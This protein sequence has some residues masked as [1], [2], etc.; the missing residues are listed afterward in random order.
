[1]WGLTIDSEGSLYVSHYG[2]DRVTK[3]PGAAIVA[4][5]N[6]RG[7]TLN[8]LDYPYNIFVNRD[9]TVFVADHYNHRVMK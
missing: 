2:G 7:A 4:G 6:G 8:Q 9:Q 5:G 1:M 3:R